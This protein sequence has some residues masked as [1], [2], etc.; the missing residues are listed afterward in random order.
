MD[1]TIFA[2]RQIHNDVRL[3]HRNFLGI[4]VIQIEKSHFMTKTKTNSFDILYPRDTAIRRR[5]SYHLAFDII[6][7]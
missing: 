6:Y 2:P 1:S 3:L 5:K 7:E 4:C